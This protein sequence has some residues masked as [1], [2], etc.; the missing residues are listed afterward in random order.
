MISRRRRDEP[1]EADVVVA[2]LT[3]HRCATRAPWNSTPK[4]TSSLPTSMKAPPA[5]RDAPRSAA[6][7][8]GTEAEATA[9]GPRTRLRTASDRRVRRDD[10][11]VVT[12]R[13]PLSRPISAE[14]APRRVKTPSRCSASSAV[15]AGS[16]HRCRP[17][18]SA[19]LRGVVIRSPCDHRQVALQERTLAALGQLVAQA[20]SSTRHEDGDGQRVRCSLGIEE[21]VGALCPAC[22]PVDEHGICRHDET[23]AGDPGRGVVRHLRRHEATADRV[24][25]EQL[26]RGQGRRATVLGSPAARAVRVVN[27]ASSGSG[28]VSSR[29][30]SSSQVRRS[31]ADTCPSE[32]LLVR[33]SCHLWT[34]RDAA[35]TR[36]PQRG[37]QAPTRRPERDASADSAPQSGTQAPPRRLRGRRRRPRRATRRS[38][39]RVRRGRGSR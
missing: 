18:S 23:E 4:R 37:T 6:R 28:N 35:P 34:T 3:A 1:S 29:Y 10:R 11:S 21:H 8:G 22:M 33:D 27:G 38:P 25:Q 15:I 26:G 9:S 17:R 7:A 24:A 32:R 12:H 36:R 39:H 13:I 14:R 16:G 19:V 2:S 30:A 20:P 5:L 31:M